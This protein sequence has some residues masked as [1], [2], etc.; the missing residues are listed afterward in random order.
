MYDFLLKMFDS[1]IKLIFAIIALFVLYLFG[2]ALINGSFGAWYLVGAVVFIVFIT[3]VFVPFLI[4]TFAP[5]DK[6]QAILDWY[7]WRNR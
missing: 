6:Q 5:K 1:G 4:R 3:T 2:N 7:F